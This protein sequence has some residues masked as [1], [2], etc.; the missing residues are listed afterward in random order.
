MVLY[1]CRGCRRHRPK[2]HCPFPSCLCHHRGCPDLP[3]KTSYLSPTKRNY[4]CPTNYPCRPTNRCLCRSLH[5]HGGHLLPARRRVCYPVRAR[6]C[7]G[8]GRGHAHGLRHPVVHHPLDA[9]WCHPGARCG[10]GSD[11]G[12]HLDEHSCCAPDRRLR[13]HASCRRRFGEGCGSSYHLLSYRS[14]CP[15]VSCHPLSNLSCPRLSCCSSSLLAFC[16]NPFSL[17]LSPPVSSPCHH[18]WRFFSQR[19]SSPRLFFCHSSR[20]PSF[21][22]A[23]SQPPCFRRAPL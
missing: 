14:S 9:C 22:L 5:R 19:V 17:L 6:V 11:A 1:C 7:H 16:Q 18:P 13:C 10:F 21:Q 20:H 12:L 4:P 2:N 3:T 8:H 23:F 15:P